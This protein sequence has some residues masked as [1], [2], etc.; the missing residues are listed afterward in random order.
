MY[1][2]MIHTIMMYTIMMYRVWESEDQDQM[3]RRAEG[4]KGKENT[5]TSTSIQAPEHI[6]HIEH[7]EHNIQHTTYQHINISTYK[8]LSTI[9]HIRPLMSYVLCLTPRAYSPRFSIFFLDRLHTLS[10]F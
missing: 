6:E 7:T 3:G 5:I 8:I 2:I 1:A 10:I 4:Q 9:Y